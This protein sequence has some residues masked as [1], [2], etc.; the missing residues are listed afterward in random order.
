[1]SCE[2]DWYGNVVECIRTILSLVILA[3]SVTDDANRRKLFC[4]LN[5]LRAIVFL[6]QSAVYIFSA[7]LKA[8]TN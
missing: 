8:P 7:W 1:M 5:L 3:V 6:P 4:N 2:N